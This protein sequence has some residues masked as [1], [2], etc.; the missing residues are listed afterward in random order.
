MDVQIV[1]SG[2][3]AMIIPLW[4]K[5][6]VKDSITYFMKEKQRREHCSDIYIVPG[7]IYVVLFQCF[8]VFLNRFCDSGYGPS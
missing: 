8:K 5:N 7:R 3:F 6:V 1:K 2:Y 4:L